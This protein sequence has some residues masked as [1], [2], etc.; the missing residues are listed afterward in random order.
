MAK[1]ILVYKVKQANDWTKLPE[2][3]VKKLVDAWGEWVG[4]FSA[5]RTDGGAFKFGGKSV[6]SQGVAD[7]DNLMTGYATIDAKDFD[8]ALGIAKK[9]PNVIDGSGTI[10]VY[11]AFAVQ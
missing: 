2:Q 10:E 7:A 1:Y 9:A 6:G 5:S 3:E 11:E 8:E 4:T